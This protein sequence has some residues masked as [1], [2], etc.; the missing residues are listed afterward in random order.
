MAKPRTLTETQAAHLIGISYGTLNKMRRAGKVPA[1]RQVG[2]R[3][4]YLPE[5]V[6]RFLAAKQKGQITDC[7][8]LSERRASEAR[9]G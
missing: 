3:V 2:R 8:Q 6:D 4:F 5:D 1:W 9:F 7:D